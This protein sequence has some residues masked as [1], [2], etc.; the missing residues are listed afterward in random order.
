MKLSLLKCCVCSGTTL[1]RYL[2]RD[3]L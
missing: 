3:T 1:A 2:V